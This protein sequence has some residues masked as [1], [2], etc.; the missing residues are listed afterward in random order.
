VPIFPH[1]PVRRCRDG[2]YEI[3]IGE[4]EQRLLRTYLEQLRD[5]LLSD[6][7]L[8][9]RLFPPAYLDDPDHDR[10]YQQ[11]MKGELIESRFA[12]IETMEATL[13]Q[14]Y[15]DQAALTRWMQAINSLRLV[16]GTR[17]DVSEDPGPIDRD[18]P[19]FG[20]RVLYEQLGWMLAY[21]VEALT[22]G[23]PPPTDEDP[24]LSI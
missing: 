8:L 19:D 4:I 17:L 14:R 7:P 24:E 23:L 6:D 15:V 9:R 20:L 21:I 22:K 1:P 5:L 16:V 18:D 12:A 10:A 2:R 11:M 13:G 3:T